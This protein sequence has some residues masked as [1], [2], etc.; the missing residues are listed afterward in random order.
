MGRLNMKSASSILGAFLLCLSAS[1]V[2]DVNA[3]PPPRVDGIAATTSLDHVVVAGRVE[4]LATVNI[5]GGADA[6]SGSADADSGRFAV[7][8][9][10]TIGSNTLEVFAVDAAGNSSESAS[11]V[12]VREE[13]RA[14]RVRIAL[15]T[16]LIDADDGSLAVAVD[17]DNDEAAVDLSSLGVTLAMVGYPRDIAPTAVLFD[18]TGHGRALI[19]GLDAIGSGTIVAEAD[20]AAP[21]GSRASATS[22]FVVIAGQPASVT[23]QLA[24]TVDGAAVGPDSAITVPPLTTVD[25]TVVVTDAAGNAVVGEPLALEVQ[26][27]GADA[28]H[29]IG[30]QISN[31]TRAGSYVVVAQLGESL[32]AASATL[33]VVPGAPV[34]LQLV[35]AP[36]LAVAGTDVTVSARLLDAQD[37]LIT[38]FPVE[39]ASDL[40]TVDRL[41]V[42]QALAVTAVDGGADGAVNV[43]TAG[44]FTVTASASSLSVP[45]A[46]AGL[47][48]VPDVIASG[49]L[50]T[51]PTPLVAGDVL[52]V[53]PVFVDRFDN[54]VAGPF[55][56]ATD[57]PGAIVIADRILGLT[58]ANEGGAPYNVLVTPV[59]SAVVAAGTVVVVAAAPARIVLTTSGTQVTAGT[60][61]TATAAVED[62]FG[63]R[64]LGSAPTLATSSPQ[65]LTVTSTGG[66]ATG[67]VTV[68]TAGSF[69]VSASDAGGIVA[70]VAVPLVVVA[71]VVASGSLTLEPA[72]LV[73]GGVLTVTPSFVDRFDNV[74]TTPFTVATDAPGAVVAASR[75]L[76]VTKANEGGAPFNVL[77]SAAGTAVVA[78]AV[79]VVVAAAPDALVLTTTSQQVTAGTAVIATAFVRDAFG[80]RVRGAAPLLEETSAQGFAVTSTAGVA[81]GTMT[82]TTAGVFAITA[83]DPAAVLAAVTVP[84]NVV[85]AAPI[86]ANFFDIDVAGLPYLAG[87]PVFFTYSFVDA[88]GNVFFDVPLLVSVNA[89]NTVVIIDGNGGG[90]IDG[91]VR[92]GNYVVRARAVGTGLVDNTE[93]LAVGPN[94]LDAGFNLSLSAGLISEGGTALFSTTDGFGNA[95]AAADVALTFT[96]PATPTVSGN[97]LVFP[98]PGTYSVEACLVA[99]PTSCDTEFI[100]VQGIIDTVPPTVAVTITSPNSA[101]SQTVPP[102]GLVTF[103][104]DSSDDRGL[105]ELRFVAT[106]ADQLGTNTFCTTQSGSILLRGGTLSDSRTFSFSLPACAVPLDSI[107]IVAQAIDQAGNSANSPDHSPLS[108]AAPFTISAPGFLTSVAA[109]QGGL[110]SPVDVAVT[111]GTG[112]L[113]VS[114]FGG[115]DITLVAPDRTQAD[116]RD[117]NGRALSPVEPLGIA[118]DIAGNL[119]IHSADPGNNN[120]LPGIERLRPDFTDDAPFIDS[121]VVGGSYPDIGS[122]IALDETA[123]RTPLLCAALTAAGR[124]QCFTNFSAAVATKAMPINLSIAGTGPVAPVF[125]PPFG[126]A[127]GDRLWVALGTTRQIR[128]F[129]FN[130]ARTTLTLVSNI[131]VTATFGANQMGDMVMATNTGNFLVSRTTTGQVVRVTQAGAVS[132]VASGFTEPV[133]LAFD[134][135]SLLIVD[136]SLETVFRL[137]PDP[138]NPGTF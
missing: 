24:A 135:A 60:L 45:V 99:S 100:S 57:A 26:G 13:P 74:V 138:A 130:A 11:L 82:V 37:N 58:T 28:A 94:P 79:L 1:C 27:A 35:V 54:E 16:A 76:G 87:D 68:T 123:S 122:G 71:D 23:L 101:Q 30:A 105:S 109:F 92:A 62:V 36:P 137:T 40:P 20:V 64:V 124:V 90:E 134:G 12:I 98:A 41:G 21:D 125:D 10:L 72:P 118:N 47:T 70:A 4:Y 32:L 5:T 42:A 66:I 7:D 103:R 2:S 113:F 55:D 129:T 97:Q 46:T 132:V 43:R 8:V 93:S 89:P 136:R 29:I 95:I 22:G 9:P 65:P 104:V 108:V 17:I 61:V 96:G 67:T 131:D 59:G 6:A 112:E 128:Q 49:S 107:K 111:V 133:G 69:A 106:F 77:V 31:L 102:R 88:F 84:L 119:F 52:T 121:T 34:R 38:G 115:D 15:E 126:A 86:N 53:T 3:P 33:L 83:S 18:A 116:L 117:R 73:A 14:E 75:I 51:D 127:T 91:I 50:S 85:H 48:V 78:S 25:A 19:T 44:N 39:L 120:G 80:N 81:T 114:N 110:N 56:V 63:N